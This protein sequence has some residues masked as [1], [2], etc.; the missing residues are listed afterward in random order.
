MIN[1]ALRYRVQAPFVDKLLN[2]I[3]MSGGDITKIGSLLKSVE[4]K[5]D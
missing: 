5:G 1:A 3:G 4:D 2:E